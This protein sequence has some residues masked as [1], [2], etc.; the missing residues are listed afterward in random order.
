VNE[1]GEPEGNWRG[2]AKSPTLRLLAMG[3]LMNA[4]VVFANNSAN[5]QSSRPPTLEVA[6]AITAEP[7]TQVPFAIRV[8]P[9]ALIPRSSFVR[10]R[11]M[12]P[13]VAL[14]EGYSIAPGAWAVPLQSLSDLKIIIPVAVQ[15]RSKISVSLVAIDGSVLVEVTSTLTVTPSI[16]PPSPPAE[17]A[18]AGAPGQLASPERPEHGTSPLIP[19]P[20]LRAEDREQALKL[21]Q[22]GDEQLSQGLVATA[23]LLYERAA[24]LGLA[25]AA[26]ALAATYDPTELARTTVR[27]I[28]P[29]VNEARRWYERARQLD[30]SDAD[31]RLR[32][33]GTN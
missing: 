9:P 11:G 30:A 2:N 5:A 7:A 4:V 26:M 17:A 13:M 8:G 12:P 18:G 23:R 33:L 27:G 24:D 3:A 32:R 19:A 14:S 1:A 29:D 21:M 10:V 25:Q 31:Q 20:T 6:A 28:S 15:G 16:R 22:K